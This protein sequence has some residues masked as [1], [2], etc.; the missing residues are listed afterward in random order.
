MFGRHAI[1][2]CER[3]KLRKIFKR[4]VNQS[5]SH[6]SNIISVY[7]IMHEAADEQFTEDNYESLRS[8]LSECF[9]LSSKKLKG[10]C[11]SLGNKI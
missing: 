2:N 4:L 9:D 6:A 3:R 8:F 11:F 10:N 7:H 5:P 1:T